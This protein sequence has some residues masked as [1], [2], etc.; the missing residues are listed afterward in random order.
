[1]T[2]AMPALMLAAGASRRW[3]EANK[4]LHPVGGVPLIRRVADALREGGVGSL[5]VTMRPGDDALR[6]AFRGLE[7]I[8]WVEVTDADRGIGASVRKGFEALAKTSAMELGFLVSPGDLLWLT[9][10]S[11]SQILDAFVSEEGG[12]AVVPIFGG[13]PG[14]PV[15]LPGTWLQLASAIPDYRGAGILF[16]Q[17]P[18]RVRR[19]ELRDAGI[20]RDCDRPSDLDA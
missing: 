8:H 7:G 1:M 20:V 12:N 19:L 17:H 15:A 13:T 5:W 11:V 14:H 2:S 4:L 6:G 9:G 18:D 16:A 10:S 3:G